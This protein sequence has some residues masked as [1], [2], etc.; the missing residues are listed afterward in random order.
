MPSGSI[1]RL[2]WPCRSTKRCVNPSRANVSA[3]EA[4]GAG[5]SAASSWAHPEPAWRVNP[6][7]SAH[8]TSIRRIVVSRCLQ[9]RF[10]VRRRFRTVESG[11]RCLSLRSRYEQGQCHAIHVRA[12]ACRRGRFRRRLRRLDRGPEGS[13][14][15]RGAGRRPT[16]RCPGMS[17][18]V[19][20]RAARAGREADARTLQPI[21][22]S[23]PR[24]TEVRPERRRLPLLEPH[25]H[26]ELLEVLLE[27]L[28][29]ER[30]F[31]ATRRIPGPRA[32]TEGSR[33]R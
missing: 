29:A 22:R 17:G 30:R 16:S 33:A 10:T 15:R 27:R 23:A 12:R 18:S 26:P 7:N 24:P 28:A 6:V 5:A 19:P 20:A 14:P 11:K 21:L 31:R 13:R 2:C 8:T 32:P 3:G 9:L 4:F 25:G 1:A